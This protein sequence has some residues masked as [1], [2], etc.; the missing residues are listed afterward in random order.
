MNILLSVYIA[1]VILEARI[2]CEPFSE[3]STHSDR[4]TDIDYFI[5]MERQCILV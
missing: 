4:V 3:H 1:D 5:D 2:G